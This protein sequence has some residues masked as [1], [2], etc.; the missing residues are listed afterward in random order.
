MDLVKRV[1]LFGG[2]FDP[3]HRAHIA[4]AKA[5]A[6]Q[7]NL[8]TIRFVPVGFPA[9]K[10]PSASFSQ[11]CTMVEIAINNSRDKR[12]VIDKGETYDSAR[13]P[14]YSFE[15]I[16]R[17]QKELPDSELFLILG[18]DQFVNFRTWKNWKWILQNIN[19]AVCARPHNGV[20]KPIKITS[21][22]L[23]S[24]FRDVFKEKIFIVN[25]KLDDSS[26]TMLR[27][28]LKKNVGL[29]NMVDVDVFEYIKRSKLYQN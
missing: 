23:L 9:Q 29:G 19:L 6:N 10:T 14:N 21:T 2:C 25:L 11:R 26:S 7:L 22:F 18:E 3:I 28:R 27:R 5:T 20:D 15:T 17:I 13:G 4:F 24:K 12:L 16:M 8:S 1:G